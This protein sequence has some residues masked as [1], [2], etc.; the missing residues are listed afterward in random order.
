MWPMPAKVRR[1]ATGRTCFPVYPPGGVDLSRHDPDEG[2]W[3]GGE[4]N[5]FRYRDHVGESMVRV[6]TGRLRT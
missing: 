6:P 2:L 3:P 1:L 4:T 5:D